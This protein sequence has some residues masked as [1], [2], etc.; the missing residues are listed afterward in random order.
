MSAVIVVFKS[1]FSDREESRIEAY[2]HAAG[3]D[4]V[5]VTHGGPGDPSFVAIDEEDLPQSRRKAIFRAA[6]G[7]RKRIVPY[8]S[9]NP[10]TQDQIEFLR[11]DRL[12]KAGIG[13][14]QDYQRRK[15]LA[16]KVK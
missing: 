10:P 2:M 12:C 5:Y 7:A 6:M 8:A 1:R 3:E 4:D 15:M 9:D 11:L 13:T 16:K 14:T